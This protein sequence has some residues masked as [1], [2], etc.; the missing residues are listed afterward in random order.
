MYEQENRPPHRSP[1]E[2]AKERAKVMATL[3]RGA[4]LKIGG[5]IYYHAADVIEWVESRKAK[6]KSPQE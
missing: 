3:P 2:L 4:W 5:Q 6:A 1:D